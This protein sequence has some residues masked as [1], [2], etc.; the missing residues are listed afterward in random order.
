MKTQNSEK[1]QVFSFLHRG[2]NS[3]L[4]IIA[5]SGVLVFW[6]KLNVV[7]LFFVTS[8]HGR[9][10]P[11]G[12]C[13]QRIELLLCAR[14][15]ASTFHIWRWFDIDKLTQNPTLLWLTVLVYTVSIFF[16]KILTKNQC[17][18]PTL[19]WFVIDISFVLKIIEREKIVFNILRR[20]LKIEWSVAESNLKI[21]GKY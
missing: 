16:N 9:G 3:L 2:I 6:T 21:I 17:Q 14:A 19:C 1:N 4:V 13:W 15:F 18:Y 7:R 11:R 12:D 20:G 10:D 5:I 8:E